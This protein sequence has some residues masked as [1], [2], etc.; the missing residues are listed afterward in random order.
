M[1]IP[2]QRGEP[3]SDRIPTGQPQGQVGADPKC[4]EPIAAF[5][6]VQPDGLLKLEGIAWL[7]GE[8]KPRRGEMVKKL[9]QFE[10]LGV[11]LA[12]EIAR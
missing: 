11:D 6:E 5:A 10:V 2:A 1:H 4:R 8:S 7:I 12:V 9:D 3:V